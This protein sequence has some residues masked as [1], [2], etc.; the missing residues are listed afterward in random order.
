MPIKTYL[1]LFLL[2]ASIS[3]A[4]INI[5]A[6]LAGAWYEPEASGQGFFIDV[7]EVN[8]QL[9]V[10]WF[11]YQPDADTN[12][13]TQRYWLTAQGGYV[14]S[15]AELILIKTSHG[16]FDQTTA[17]EN[18]AVGFATLNFLSCQ[19]AVFNYQLTEFN[20]SG[21]INLVRLT[22]DVFCEDNL[23][24]NEPV[25]E[26]NFPPQV[27]IS[28]VS[29]QGD[30]VQIDFSLSDEE[31][32][33]LEI[34]LEASGQNSQGATV[35]YPIPA[36]YLVGHVGYPVLPGSGK[37]VYWD[38]RNDLGFQALGLNQ[39]QLKVTADDRYA[40]TIQEIVDLASEER[41]IND[42][43][44][45]QGV[46]H[47]QASPTGLANA[48]NY[49]RETMQQ[50]RLS[51]I[52]EPFSHQGSTGINLIAKHPGDL[53]ANQVYIVDGH[54]DTVA[55]TPGA[56]DNASG[57][58]GMLE[59]MRVLSQFNTAYTLKFIAFDKEELGLVGSRYHVN[60]RDRSETIRG[61]INF[62]MI[63]YTCTTQ[64]ECLQFPN[65]DTSIYNIKSSFA[66]TLSD[67]FNQIG[68]THVP[69]LKI[70]PVTDDGDFNFR[71]SDHA[72][73]WDIG[74]DALFL[75]DGANFR[76]PHYHQT[77]DLLPTLDT[78]FM[79]Q[80]VKTTIGTL[81]QLAQ[82][83]HSGSAISAPFEITLIP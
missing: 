16:V 51:V 78:A 5:N 24:P 60:N 68:A 38:H 58:A 44:N 7:I 74:V 48:R 6:G 10:G 31:Q 20:R 53:F 2:H 28:E 15:L 17:V 63:G 22:P 27:Q 54:Y 81:A 30:V 83:T 25:A 35:N 11:T 42:I 69:A 4:E 55:N 18:S 70:T 49:L 57:T 47:H 29:E 56:D 75:S 1:I 26:K 36:A 46:R 50:A 34:K 40:S 66:N 33:L 13:E 80:V 52:E 43:Q 73:F 12:G 14:G 61:L 72:P 82:I 39:L 79:T 23:V 3:T 71:R 64:P 65:A 45:L 67:T 76:T 37:L 32:D 77:S 8:Q 9:F 19:Q 62:E 21:Q 59:V 41:L